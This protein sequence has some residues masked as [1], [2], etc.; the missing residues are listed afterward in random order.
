MAA[1]TLKAEDLIKQIADLKKAGLLDRVSDPFAGIGAVSIGP[2]AQSVAQAVYRPAPKFGEENMR[3]MLNSRM[4][5][6]LGD[7]MPFQ[8]PH[9]RKLD[10]TQ[11]VVFI[12][13]DG[14]ALILKDE[15]ALYPSDALV[16]QIRLLCDGK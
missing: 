7:P 15:L 11:A 12:Q 5:W 2:N 10:D 3:K 9:A 1:G 4:G 13:H 6:D 14:H 16:T 8:W